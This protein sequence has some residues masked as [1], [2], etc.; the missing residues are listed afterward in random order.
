[1]RRRVWGAASWLIGGRLV[2][3]S[4]T[5]LTLLAL[6]GHLSDAD[7]GRLTFW[8]A[9]FLVLDGVVDFGAGSGHVGLL[10]AFRARA[11]ASLLLA[12]AVQVRLPLR[13]L[14]PSGARGAP[15][16]LVC[17]SSLA[18][19]R[20]PLCLPRLA[21]LAAPAPR[22]ASLMRAWAKAAA[23]LTCWRITDV[24]QARAS[25]SERVPSVRHCL[26]A[27]DDAAWSMR[28]PTSREPPAAVLPKPLPPTA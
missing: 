17:A 6:T 24:I 20:C 18:L 19:P 1:M 2:S 10:L 14:F 4:C 9:V 22:R 3:S 28:I 21:R 15:K 12:G 23:K 26:C 27:A 11:L 25:A 13:R 5:L 8:L 16:A 7:F